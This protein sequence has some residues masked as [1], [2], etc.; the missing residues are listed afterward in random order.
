MMMSIGVGVRMAEPHFNFDLERMK[1]ALEGP[2]LTLPHGLTREERRWYICNAKFGSKD[3]TFEVPPDLTMEE[4][5][6]F[7]KRKYAEAQE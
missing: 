7:A 2:T 1:K 6:E 3:G 4:L 5:T